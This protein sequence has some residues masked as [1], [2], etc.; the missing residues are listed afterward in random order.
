[1]AD[2]THD[3]LSV[4]MDGEC[5]NTEQEFI[6]RRLLKDSQLKDQWQRYHLISD[7]VKN[8]LPNKINMDFAEGIMAVIAQEE[9]DSAIRPSLF[10]NH[11]RKPA[12]GFGLAASI[13]LAS[14]IGIRTWLNPDAMTHSGDIAQASGSIETGDN[15][16][17]AVDQRLHA[18]LM[19]HNGYASLSG[20]NHVLPYVRMVGFQPNR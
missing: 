1:M 18:Y 9:P 14:L 6:L 5:Q 7:T 13:A 10:D 11:W 4:L 3:Q 8:H 15:A 17:D 19:N 2:H 12:I 20:A 16:L